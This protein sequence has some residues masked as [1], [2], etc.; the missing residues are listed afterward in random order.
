MRVS[1]KTR[2]HADQKC[3]TDREEIRPPALALHI[4]FFIKVS[5]CVVFK[6]FHL[7]CAPPH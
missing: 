5:L 1:I 2:F 4:H 3:D 7:S 6:D